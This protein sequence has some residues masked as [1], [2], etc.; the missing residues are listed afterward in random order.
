MHCTQFET[1]EI[2]ENT[3][4]LLVQ[5]AI[6]PSSVC[7]R[8]NG[9]SLHPDKNHISNDKHDISK[10]SILYKLYTAPHSQRLH[11]MKLLAISATN[12][13]MRCLLLRARVNE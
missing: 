6:Y 7:I 2:E 12:D 3:L 8:I 4:S 10:L 1:S 11:C 13:S 9:N 5:T